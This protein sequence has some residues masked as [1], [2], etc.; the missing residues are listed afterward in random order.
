MWV[1]RMSKLFTVSSLFTFFNY[2]DKFDVPIE[3]F[4][5]M[6]LAKFLNTFAKFIPVFSV[7]VY[8]YPLNPDTIFVAREV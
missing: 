2:F 1:A 5:D 3:L 6:Y 7:L 4:S 8:I